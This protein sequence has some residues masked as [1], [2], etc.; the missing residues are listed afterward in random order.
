MGTGR[1]ASAVGTGGFLTEKW[2]KDLWVT[3]CCR[4]PGHPKDRVWG[5]A[6]S[7]RRSRAPWSHFTNTCVP[8]PGE[9]NPGTGSLESFEK[10]FETR[11][12]SAWLGPRTQADGGALLLSPTGAQPCGLCWPSRP[13]SSLRGVRPQRSPERCVRVAWEGACPRR[14]SGPHGGRHPAEARGRAGLARVHTSLANG[15]RST[16]KGD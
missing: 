14:A 16:E 12:P 10:A 15:A 11:C 1:T 3:F 5:A 13:C 2:Q 8:P 6:V 7:P 4:L 9:G